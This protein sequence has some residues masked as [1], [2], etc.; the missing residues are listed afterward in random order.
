MGW[1]TSNDLG[2]ADHAVGD[3]ADPARLAL[4]HQDTAL[5][6]SML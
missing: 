3:E 6:T 1:A 4:G 2:V 5:H